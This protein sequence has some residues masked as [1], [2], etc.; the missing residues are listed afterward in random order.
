V[1]RILV[2]ARALVAL[3]LAAT[4]GPSGIQTCP[5]SPED[6]FLWLIAKR[7]PYVYRVLAYGY[8]TL[9]FRTPYFA[10]SLLMSFVTIVTYRRTPSA[11]VRPIAPHQYPE[12]READAWS[13]W[14]TFDAHHFVARC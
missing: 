5:V 3:M 13:W 1:L 9:W 4:A 7:A 2:E 11:R 12:V 6:V 10:T 8:A 14:D